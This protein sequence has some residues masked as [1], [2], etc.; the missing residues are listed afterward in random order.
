MRSA[1]DRQDWLEARGARVGASGWTLRRCRLHAVVVSSVLRT[2][3]MLFALPL[4]YC[5]AAGG[6]RV[7]GEESI[8]S[9]VMADATVAAAHN[10]RSG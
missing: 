5:V 10:G 1:R 4:A 3:E 2:A 8:L 6:N 7:L 9:V